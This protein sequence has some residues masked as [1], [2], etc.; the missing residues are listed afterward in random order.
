MEI[1]NSLDNIIFNLTSIA[2]VILGISLIVYIIFYNSN[3]LEI[4]SA[5]LQLL[6]IMFGSVIGI[7]LFIF[8]PFHYL[9][10]F[11]DCIKGETS[12]LV[13]WKLFLGVNTPLMMLWI[14][15]ILYIIKLIN[16]FFN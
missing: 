12:K 14:A 15:A 9:T 10:T 6:I 8:Y 7:A 1:I 16:L 2:L 3:I 4:V 11:R 5:P 13:N